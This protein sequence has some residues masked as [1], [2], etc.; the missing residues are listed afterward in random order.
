MKI[1][2]FLVAIVFSFNAYSQI[3]A[4]TSKGDEVILYD[5]G[6]WKY[7]SKPDSEKEIA[8]NPTKFVKDPQSTFQVTSNV[9]PEASIYVNPK[10]WSFQK[11]ESGAREYTFQLKEKDAYGM[12]I[13]ERIEI[14]L[15]NLKKIAIQNA[16]NAAPDISVVK[17]EYRTVNGIKVLLMQMNG[18][19]QGIQFSYYGYYY[20]FKGGSVQFLTY[21]SQNLFT[22]YLPHF[23]SL[24]NGL[25]IKQ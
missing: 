8:V 3:S 9:I 14:P 6:T 23:E 25:V 19:I 15:E 22:E 10:V 24:L 7:A 2:S 18:T 1:I 12:L 16:K 20:S 5:N 4:V 21:T 11:A 17:E 13:P